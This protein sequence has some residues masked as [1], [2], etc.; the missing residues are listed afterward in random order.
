MS[1]QLRRY[2]ELSAGGRHY[3]LPVEQVVEVGEP[4]AVLP[5]P[6]QEPA[7]RGV[8]EARGRLVPIL[9]LAAFLAGTACPVER[10]TALVL[11]RSGDAAARRIVAL[12]VDD[13]FAVVRGPVL[14]AAG[15]P[16]LPWA[17]GLA[18][19]TSDTIP[20][21]DLSALAERLRG[22]GAPA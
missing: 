21:L 3:G 5:A 17:I 7:L 13:V 11:V 15:L 8:T 6:T 14:P 20:I 16:S 10:G 9:H 2:L 1:E 18:R 4:G 22:I 12:E 19:R